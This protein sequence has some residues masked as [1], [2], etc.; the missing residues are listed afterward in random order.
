MK[1]HLIIS[2]T[3]VILILGGCSKM[4]E[5]EKLKQGTTP[6]Q[7]YVGQGFSF[8]DGEKTEGI[9]EKYEKEIAAQAKAYV[10][11]NYHTE[12]K[13]NNV[14]PA[15]NAA[16]VMVE[17]EEP[18]SFHSSVIVS[19]DMRGK[20]PY[21]AEDGMV[22]SEEGELENAIVSGL[23]HKLYRNEF[24]KLTANIERCSKK[25]GL[26]PRTEEV[27]EK[28]GTNGYQNQYFFITVF[29]DDSEILNIYKEEKN[30]SNNKLRQLFE[31]KAAKENI[32][33]VINLFMP[34]INDKPDK[35]KIYA[36]AN[37]IKNLK[38]IPKAQ[39][40]F[41]VF[42]NE[43]INQHALTDG[44]NESIEVYINN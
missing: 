35:K 40:S 28:T 31:S 23:F 9:V 16:V 15:R 19:L 44:E 2:V 5:K 36:L 26:V 29:F 43:I 12:V 38:G 13:V 33:I 11:K 3:I 24:E 34:N 17:A 20:K 39:Y 37:D 41:T 7:D 4:D 1:K 30:V 27:I 8:V 22:R 10:K 14:V 18:I 25:I 6:V 32:S 21:P 42:G